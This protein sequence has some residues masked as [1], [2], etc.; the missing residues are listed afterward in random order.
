M[1]SSVILRPDSRPLP[2]QS[3]YLYPGFEIFSDPP[4]PL[5]L[6][7]SLEKL[8]SVVDA[9]D[10]KVVLISGDVNR[11]RLA[12]KLNLMSSTR[13]LWPNLPYRVARASGVSS[14]AGAG[15]G[16][17]SKWLGLGGEAGTAGVREEE[18]ESF[19]EES[20]GEDDV[21]FLQFTSG[22]TSEPKGVMITFK[23]LAHNARFISG[24]CE[25]VCLGV[26]QY[27][28]SIMPVRCDGWCFVRFFLFFFPFFFFIFFPSFY[29]NT[30]AVKI[31]HKR[32][33][34]DT[35]LKRGWS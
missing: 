17:V 7:K 26:H 1:Y 23:N 24:M 21:A 28:T 29:C 12:S 6:S 25:K 35:V 19:D 4:S 11:L 33:V 18:A 34:A 16:R 2:S 15:A 27:Y 31:H 10:P 32:Y 3:S 30:A 8:Q 14:G 5:T 9:C 13:R 20:L 22:S